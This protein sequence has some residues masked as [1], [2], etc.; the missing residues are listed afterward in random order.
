LGQVSKTNPAEAKEADVG[1]AAAT[2][3]AAVHLTAGELWFAFGFFD[4]NFTSH[5]LL[6]LRASAFLKGMPIRSNILLDTA[7]SL[8][9]VTIMI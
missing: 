8:A 4:L 1:A 7:G 9:V 3:L 5:K 2:D 6:Y